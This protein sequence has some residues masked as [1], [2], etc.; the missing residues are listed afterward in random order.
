MGLPHEE[1]DV[2]RSTAADVSH[3]LCELK[4]TLADPNQG[5]YVEFSYADSKYCSQLSTLMDCQ[6]S[7]SLDAVLWFLRLRHVKDS[8][9]TT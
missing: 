4:K 1:R 7:S 6:K 3:K 8:K 5:R 9:V 2:A